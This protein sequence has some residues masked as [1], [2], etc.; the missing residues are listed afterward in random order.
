[1]GDDKPGY[2]R[3]KSPGSRK[4]QIKPGERRSPGRT[5]GSPNRNSIIRKVLDQI[6]T[7]DAA[8]KRRKVTVTEASLLRLA[9]TALKGD[10]AAIKLV[11]ALWKESEDGIARER[12]REYPMS[13]ADRDVIEEMYRRMKAAE[14]T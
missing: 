5:P 4:T 1:M 2:R 10:L 14:R 3:G 12:E 9:Q 7:G 13:E 11:L 8:G 6:V